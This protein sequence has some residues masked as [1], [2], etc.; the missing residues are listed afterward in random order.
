MAPFTLNSYSSLYYTIHKDSRLVI[1]LQ[2]GCVFIFLS[3][4]QIVCLV[5]MNFPLIH[6]E[7]HIYFIRSCL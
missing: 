4:Y 7:M 6:R 5:Y 2:G 1:C 3:V